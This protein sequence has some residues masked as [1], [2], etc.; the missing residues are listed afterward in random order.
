MSDAAVAP[1]APDPTRW[2]MLGV[3]A[4]AQLMIILDGSI[5]NVALPH[6]QEA[7]GI[8]D[9]NR[10]WVVTAYTLAFGGLLLLGGRIADYWGRK[11]TFLVGL[12]GFAGASALGGLAPS[13][14][15]I[16]A[17]RGLQGVFAALLAP[18]AL[19]LV[20]VAFTRCRVVA[21]RSG[22]SSAGS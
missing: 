2:R 19:S 9:A 3:I 12:L 20:T 15:F 4:I 1:T 10:Q 14:E 11:R 18:A 8:S 21:R 6:M 5:V 22:S 17:A 7:L 16:F 13:Q